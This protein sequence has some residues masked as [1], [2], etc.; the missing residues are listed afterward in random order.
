MAAV[1][2]VEDEPEEKDAFNLLQEL[3]R[4]E[5]LA[6]RNTLCLPHLRSAYPLEVFS[7][8]ND[9]TTD[10]SKDAPRSSVAGGET[11]SRSSIVPGHR[12]DFA[13]SSSVA[14]SSRSG[15]PRGRTKDSGVIEGHFKDI[16]RSS[17][18]DSDSRSTLSQSD[19]ENVSK[20]KVHVII[21]VMLSSSSGRYG[22][23]VGDEN[24]AISSL[25]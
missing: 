20:H 6:R 7:T 13:R 10:Q 24:S 4:R 19:Q 1:L 15:I 11:S 22:D 3:A 2:E 25:I 17:V 16:S 14:E 18:I 21:I 8:D 23:G 12:K 9:I 5:E